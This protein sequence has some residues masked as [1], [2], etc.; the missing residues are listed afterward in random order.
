MDCGI[1]AA[2]DNNKNN[3]LPNSGKRCQLKGQSGGSR[4]RKL[5]YVG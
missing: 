2:G 3:N 1:L 5:S 4:L